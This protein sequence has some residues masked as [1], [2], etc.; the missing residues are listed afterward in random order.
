MKPQSYWRGGFIDV[1]SPGHMLVDQISYG[2]RHVNHREVLIKPVDQTH[3]FHGLA[4][5]PHR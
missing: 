4:G 3:R 1:T 2:N 5:R